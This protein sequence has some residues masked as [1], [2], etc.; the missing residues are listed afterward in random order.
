MAL[1]NTRYRSRAAEQPDVNIS[2]NTLP[3]VSLLAFAL[4]LII[5]GGILMAVLGNPNAKFPASEYPQRIAG[6]AV[7]AGGI[8]IGIAGIIVSV[9]IKKKG[10]TPVSNEQKTSSR[11]VSVSHTPRACTVSNGYSQP[12]MYGPPAPV[13]MYNGSY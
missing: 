6:P 10:C 8:A 7:M 5:I 11:A 12:P 13:V 9:Y 1:D 3:G 2:N 4:I